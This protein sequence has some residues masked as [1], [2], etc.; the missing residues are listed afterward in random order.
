MNDITLEV[1]ASEM[2][3]SVVYLIKQFS[4]IGIRKLKEDYINPEEKTKLSNYLQSKRTQ[5][6][7]TLTLQR[8][9]RSTLSV[10]GLRGKNKKIQ[11]EIRKK[12]KFTTINTPNNKNVKKELTFNEN[13]TTNISNKKYINYKNDINN[14]VLKN[15]FYKKNNM[16]NKNRSSLHIKNLKKTEYLEKNKKLELNLNSNNFNLKMEKKINLL[17]EKHYSFYK[18]VPN[19]LKLSSKRSNKFTVVSSKKNKSNYNLNDTNIN[20]NNTQFLN[21]KNS[22]ENVKILLNHPYKGNHKLPIKNNK[23]HK[24]KKVKGIYLKQIFQKPKKIK[25]RNI[26]IRETILVSELANKMAIKSSAIIK[27]MSSLGIKIA[28]NE[29]INQKTAQLIAEKMGH[30]AILHNNNPL[31]SIIKKDLNIIDTS[32]LKTRPPIVTVMGHVDHGKTSVLDYIRSTKTVSK[33]SGGITQHIGAYHIKT[34]NNNTITFL[35]TPGHSA[36][37]A[38]RARGAQVTDIIVL[39]VA[40]DDGVKPQTI[41]AIHHSK[42]AN[43]PIVVAINKVD[44][45]GSDVE[46]IKNELTKH[47]IV[48]EKWGGENIFVNISAKTGKGISD[49]LGSILLQAEI[50]ELKTIFDGMAR[51]LVIESY[52]DKGIGPVATV[53]INEGTLKKG[54][55]IISGCEYGKVRAIRDEFGRTVSIAEPSIPVEVLGLSGIPIAGDQIVVVNN[56]KKARELALYRQSKIKE[57]KIANQKKINLENLFDK[58]KKENDIRLNIIL[59]SDVQ[60]SLEAIKGSLQSLS[61]NKSVINLVSIGVGNIT[62]TD[63]SLAIASNSIIIGFNVKSDISAKRI[64]I[65]EN[66]DVRYYSVI[67]T[68]IDEVKIAMRGLLIPE[69]KR[70]I[71]GLAEVRN[72]FGSSKLN[73]IA[74]C[75]VIE[76]TIRKKCPVRIL[77]KNIVIYEGELESL[78]HFKND[79]KEVKHGMECGISI[80]NYNN[81]NIGD[82]IEVFKDIEP[83]K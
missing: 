71:V 69:H 52:L 65:S 72:I 64:I 22:K 18:K 44:K 47:G 38:M 3:V 19:K 21:F 6:K 40:V 60:G 35:D 61:N 51:G 76:G 56:E 28:V 17:K 50:L 43:V 4:D 66:V 82:K 1:L 30:K 48:P 41:E 32:L 42:S 49:L 59:K 55:I 78:R 14:D 31:E 77:R 80:K 34:D 9:I 54:D 79:M 12:Q 45:P 23:L 37:T 46:K 24:Q 53:L 15:N 13:K 81:L 27:K 5:I 26:V 75:M 63:V 67:Y 7:K 33:E 73:V 16:L 11:I 10:P 58:L 29:I 39:V 8:K 25:N 68:L 2:N 20:I 70:T 62:E 83:K 57:K 36:F 74:G